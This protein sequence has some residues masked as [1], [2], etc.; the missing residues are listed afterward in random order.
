MAGCIAD[1][2]AE[3]I[4]SAANTGL[5][6]SAGIA[7]IIA[8]AAGITQGRPSRSLSIHFASAVLRGRVDFAQDKF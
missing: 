3:A 8:E 1:V 5:H 2:P 6:F 7:R 4:V